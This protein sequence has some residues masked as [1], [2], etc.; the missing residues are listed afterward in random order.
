M[1]RNV[2]MQDRLIRMTL[3]IFF[4]ILGLNTG[5]TTS[6]GI[7]LS[8]VGVVALVTA[9]MS[10]CPAYKIAGLNSKEAE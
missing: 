9:S 5:I 6:W 3:G 4:L 10:F 7:I 2:G 8:I 1:I